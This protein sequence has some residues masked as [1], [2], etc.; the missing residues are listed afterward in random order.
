MKSNVKYT[1]LMKLQRKEIK[2]INFISV[3]LFVSCSCLPLKVSAFLCL[4]L[5]DK[6]VKALANR[7]TDRETYK[8]IL[9]HWPATSCN[10]PDWRP[11]AHH[12]Y[13]KAPLP[14]CRGSADHSWGQNQTGPLCR[15]RKRS[16]I[17][18]SISRQTICLMYKTHMSQK[19]SKSFDG[20]TFQASV[21]YWHLSNSFYVHKAKHMTGGVIARLW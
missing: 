21:F 1:Y 6:Q 17:W 20:Y 7:Q 8:W 5:A 19:Q 15:P 2:L 4:W 12:L 3:S 13:W 14:L 16:N 18:R 11:E 9:H 10:H